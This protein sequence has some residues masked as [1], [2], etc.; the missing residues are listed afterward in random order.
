MALLAAFSSIRLLNVDN[1]L[2]ST[3]G[4]FQVCNVLYIDKKTIIINYSSLPQGESY[5]IQELPF[6]E[7]TV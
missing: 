6:G 3:F 1:I 7:H 5:I 2:K 4:F